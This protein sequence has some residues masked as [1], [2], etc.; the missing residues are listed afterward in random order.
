MNS[1]EG[2][3]YVAEVFGHNNSIEFKEFTIQHDQSLNNEEDNGSYYR[4]LKYLI[5][6]C[7]TLYEVRNSSREMVWSID[8]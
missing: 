7:H 1:E 3:S 5:E 2:S 6:A 8:T 4:F